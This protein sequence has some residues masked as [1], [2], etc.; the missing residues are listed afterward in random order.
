VLVRDVCRVSVGIGPF[1]EGWD[2]HL[3][4]DL[5]PSGYVSYGLGGSPA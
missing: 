2:F 3:W 5:N 4:D 1:N